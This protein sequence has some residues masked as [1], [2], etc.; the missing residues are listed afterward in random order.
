MATTTQA[1]A[2]NIASLV[3]ATSWLMPTASA[4][5]SGETAPPEPPPALDTQNKQQAKE[6][7]EKGEAF[8]RLGEQNPE[9]YDKAIAEFENAYK[10]FP[11]PV[12]ILNI[13][14]AHRLRNN[15]KQ[16]I[17]EFERFLREAPEHPNASEVRKIIP[18]IRREI[19]AENAAHRRRRIAA[20][21]NGKRMAGLVTT[22]AGV[23]GL[24]VSGY[25]LRQSI[26][27]N[28]PL[29]NPPINDVTGEPMWTDDIL[30]KQDEGNQANTLAWTFGIAGGVAVLAG[31]TLY[32][33]GRRDRGRAEARLRSEFRVVPSATNR[34]GTLAVVGHF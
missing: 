8:F 20:V 9:N 6:L 31:A 18:V 33:L 30:A 27:L 29:E 3:I 12:F 13:A 4:Q 11:S 14:Q 28:D 23:V 10:L 2:A 17:R 1:I 26:V 24:A 32:M 34:S 15:K 22:I 5:P 7:F 21:G 19:A 16:A 25:Y